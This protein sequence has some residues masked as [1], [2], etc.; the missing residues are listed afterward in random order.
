MK[1][2]LLPLKL[3]KKGGDG[4]GE[5]LPTVTPSLVGVPKMDGL[6]KGGLG[7]TEMVGGGL[8]ESA[9]GLERV[10]EVRG[11]KVGIEV[12]LGV[13]DFPGVSVDANPKAPFSARCV[14]EGRRAVVVGLSVARPLVAEG[15][16]IEGV[17]RKTVEE[18]LCEGEDEGVREKE[19]TKVCIEVMLPMPGDWDGVRLG[20]LDSVEN[21]SNPATPLRGDTVDP[22][23]KSAVSVCEMVPPMDCVWLNDP[24]D[25]MEN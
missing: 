10:A 17:L 24:K 16:A 2:E 7:E 18:P 22:S 14:K 8:A 19:G 5:V 4:E 13:T 23:L 15:L 3:I 9:N 11:E 12:V 21:L 6:A 20:T 1:G 25:V